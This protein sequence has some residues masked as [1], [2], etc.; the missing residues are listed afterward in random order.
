[1]P[2]GEKTSAFCFLCIFV[3]ICLTLNGYCFF[4][5]TCVILETLK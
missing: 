4:T 3:Q 2:A 1:M 5:T